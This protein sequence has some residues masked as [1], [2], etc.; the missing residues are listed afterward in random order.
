MC[1]K[2]IHLNAKQ[3]VTYPL[4]II[5]PKWTFKQAKWDIKQT[6]LTTVYRTNSNYQDKKSHTVKMKTFYITKHVTCGEAFSQTS[7]RHTQLNKRWRPC[8]T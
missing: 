6:R 5:R 4:T 1:W 2:L 3:S 7:N 8:Q